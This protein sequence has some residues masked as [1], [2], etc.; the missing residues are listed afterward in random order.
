MLRGSYAGGS[1]AVTARCPGATTASVSACA[2]TAPSSGLS[3]VRPTAHPAC[4]RPGF[5]PAWDAS[6]SRCRR[7]VKHRLAGPC[8]RHSRLCY[9]SARPG[10]SLHCRRMAKLS[11]AKPSHFVAIHRFAI[12]THRVGS[13]SHSIAPPGNTVP[14][15]RTVARCFAVAVHCIPK[16][17]PIRSWTSISFALLRPATPSPIESRLGLAFARLCTPKQ[18]PRRPYQSIAVARRGFASPSPRAALL[19]SAVAVLVASWP[20]YPMPLRSASLPVLRGAVR[21]FAPPLP[22]LASLCLSVPSP[23]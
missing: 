10:V 20:S 13:P 22:G 6:R 14:S 11:K 1:L 4:P 12:A 2:S 16:P 5:R 15:R 9:S 7:F 23:F 8:P 18:R 3:Q 21:C 19:R 17:S